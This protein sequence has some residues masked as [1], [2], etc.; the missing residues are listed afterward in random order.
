M[1]AL[2]TVAA[3]LWLPALVLLAAVLLGWNPAAL[4]VALAAA[5]VGARIATTFLARTA[6]NTVWSFRRALRT[7]HD[8]EFPPVLWDGTGQPWDR[9]PDARTYR[10]RAEN[11]DGYLQDWTREQIDRVWGRTSAIDPAEAGEDTD[12]R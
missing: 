9:N 6:R 11:S 7:V 12:P 1:K 10:Q 8:T 5:P 2:K 4:V 3:F